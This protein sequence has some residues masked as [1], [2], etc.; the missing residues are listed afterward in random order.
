MGYAKIDNNKPI[1]TP[2]ISTTRFYNHLQVPEGCKE[3][4]TQVKARPNS[5]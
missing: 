4:L 1:C 2:H 5:V 3:T